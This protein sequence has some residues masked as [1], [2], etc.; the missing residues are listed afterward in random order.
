MI[1]RFDTANQRGVPR[2]RASLRWTADGGCPY[3]NLSQSE[4]AVS[5]FVSS[6]RRRSRC[7]TLGRPAAPRVHRFPS[8]APDLELHR[9][10]P[11]GLVHTEGSVI[12][13]VALHY[14][15]L[16]DRDLRA[17]GV[18]QPVDDSTLNLL[19]KD[20]RVHDLSAIYCR[21]H[22]M[23]LRLVFSMVISTTSAM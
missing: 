6:S 7:I 4:S 15:S 3:M 11:P 2:A 16:V 23:N 20:G 5:G 14:A 19:F 13:E 18:R 1:H 17:Q 10:Q 12:V 9:P 22:A 21:H 8:G